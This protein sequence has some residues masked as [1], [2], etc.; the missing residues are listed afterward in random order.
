MAHIDPTCIKCAC[1]PECTSWV[2][3]Q[4]GPDHHLKA[5]AQKC[6]S[7]D[8]QDFGCVETQLKGTFCIGSSC[9]CWGLK[10]C[11]PVARVVL[12]FVAFVGDM[13]L[14]CALGFVAQPSFWINILDED[15]HTSKYQGVK[16][17]VDQIRAMKGVPTDEQLGVA[18]QDIA[19]GLEKRRKAV[20]ATRGGDLPARPSTATVNDVAVD[21][22][23][24]MKTNTPMK[25]SSMKNMM[26]KGLKNCLP[27]L[28][29]VLAGLAAA[30]VP[31]FGAL[32]FSAAATA[33]FG[34]MKGCVIV[35]FGMAMGFLVF[36]WSPIVSGRFWARP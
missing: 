16:T 31:G 4:Y 17:G 35:S 6:K 32:A 21:S 9:D 1:V 12:A 20:Q 19:A 24:S 5:M 36:D 8:G 22:V 15:S 7:E 33:F 23:S 29:T 2:A 13:L 25:L 26:K 28:A 30:W 34:C 18:D 14:G 11:D 10:N 27:C 3:E